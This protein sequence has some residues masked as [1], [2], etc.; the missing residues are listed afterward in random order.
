MATVSP[1]DGRDWTSLGTSSPQ[2]CSSPGARGLEARAG[3]DHDVE[4]D[5]RAGGNLAP[6]AHEGPSADD[7]RLH[8]G[9]RGHL[10][11]CHDHR[12]LDTGAGLDDAART[13]HRPLDR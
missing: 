5:D 9:T 3:L 6:L 1:I 8:A 7:G 10:G 2:T 13:E 12:T 11:A 4:A